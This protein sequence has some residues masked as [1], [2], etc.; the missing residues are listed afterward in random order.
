[1][2]HDRGIKPDHNGAKN[3]GGAWCTR[4]E[5]KAASRKLRRRQNLAECRRELPDTCSVA[6][7]KQPSHQTDQR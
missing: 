1:M 3:G 2:G 5:A 6:A 4:A 7:A